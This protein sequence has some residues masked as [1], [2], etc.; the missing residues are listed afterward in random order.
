MP[1][2]PLEWATLASIGEILEKT[3]LGGYS[4]RV[5]SAGEIA[6]VASSLAALLVDAVEDGASIGFMNGLTIERAA[7]YWRALADSPAGRVV[8]VAE[9]AAGVAGTVTVVPMRNEFQPH[10]AEIAKLVVHRRARGRGVGANLLIAAE[11]QARAMGRW[12]LTLFTR[13]G[14]E[15]ERLYL[16]AGWRKAGVIPEDS[17]RPDG[18]LCDGA[19][20]HKRLAR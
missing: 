6:A 14:G 19:I 1:L 17:L 4:I 7:G 3:N 2:A 8:L 13:D 5:L 12:L 11:D 18:N 15:A 20:F 9:D 10:R 16:R